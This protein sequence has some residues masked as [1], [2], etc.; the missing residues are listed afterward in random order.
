MSLAELVG[1]LAL[2]ALAWF[3]YDS[4]RAKEAA[5]VAAKAACSAENLL[6][7]DDTVAIGRLWPARDGNGRLGLRRV[8]RFEY[9]DTG[10]NRRSGSL[11]LLGQRVIVIEIGIRAA[12]SDGIVH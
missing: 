11:V 7:L 3:W 5:V 12:P 10:N 6:F 4:A 9:S 1:W 2:A 8:Y